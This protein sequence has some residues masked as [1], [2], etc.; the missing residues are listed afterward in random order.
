VSTEVTTTSEPV[1][2]QTFPSPPPIAAE[3]TLSPGQW[4]VL[5]F[6]VSDVALFGTLIVVYIFYLGKNVVG[7]TPAEALSLPLV[8][9]TTACLL[10]SSGTIYRAE[11][12]L[13]RSSQSGFIQWW[14]ATILLG[15][16]FLSGTAYEWRDLITRHHLTISRN[17]FGTTYYTLVGLHALHVTGGV[18]IMLI[19]LGLALRRQVTSANQA[20]VGLV[21][22]YW[23]F[24][25]VV[26]VVV[27]TV[28]YL[29]GR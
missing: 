6:L 13:H 3:R 29:A 18:I 12:A 16:V 22:W 9:F 4:G 25:D 21:S 23:H 15:V 26:W 24:V 7:P 20:A 2:K 10:S 27:F 28:V 8:L 19:V 1:R 17:L 5:S 11:K 14:A